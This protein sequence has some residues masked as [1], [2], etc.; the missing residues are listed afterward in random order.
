MT[1][2][3]TAVVITASVVIIIGNVMALRDIIKKYNKKRG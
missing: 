3:K 1:Y 2:L